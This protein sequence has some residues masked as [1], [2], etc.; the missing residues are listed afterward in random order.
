M[1]VTAGNKITAG[2]LTALMNRAKTEFKRRANPYTTNCLN[3]FGNGIVLSPT[4][5]A[6][7]SITAD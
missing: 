2:E 3:K 6:G 4:D 5:S 7:T 1:A